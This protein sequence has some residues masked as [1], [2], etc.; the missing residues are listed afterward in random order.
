MMAMTHSISVRVTPLRRSRERAKTDTP[1][2]MHVQTMPGFKAHSGNFSVSVSA[3]NEKGQAPRTCDTN[4][5]SISRTK[6]PRS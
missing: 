1:L 2:V 3:P 6:L 4:Q 5:P